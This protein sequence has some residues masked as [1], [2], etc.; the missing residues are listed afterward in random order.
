MIGQYLEAQEE[1]GERQNTDV[2]QTKESYKSIKRWRWR[3]KGRSELREPM[4]K[5]RGGEEVGRAD[6]RR[7]MP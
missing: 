2:V 7:T 5:P 6:H 3:G 4:S 1:S